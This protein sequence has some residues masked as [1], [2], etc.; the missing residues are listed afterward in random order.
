[1]KNEICELVFVLDRS[2]SMYGLESDTAGG[3]NRVLEEQ[4]NGKGRAF[5]TTVLFNHQT[6]VL[7]EH[8]LI[9]A[10]PEMTAE[11]VASGGSTALLDALG[12]AIEMTISRQRRCQPHQRADRVLFV[13]MTDGLENASTRWTYAQ[14][15]RLIEQEKE[16]HGWEFLFLGAYMDAV[17]E[18]SRLGIAPERTASF[19]ND[20]EGIEINF[21][22]VSKAMKYFR[23]CEELDESGW[24]AEI[25]H[26]QCR[27]G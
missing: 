18:A 21:R 26:D 12:S 9:D 20:S 7:H 27:R 6:E 15:Q 8:V 13:I 14:L 16:G 19:I 5:V 17:K 1:M 23:A 3:F 11:D 4:K 10:M 24:K 2:G 25:E 22:C